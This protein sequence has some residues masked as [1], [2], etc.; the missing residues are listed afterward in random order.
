M[1][2][3]ISSIPYGKLYTKNNRPCILDPTRNKLLYLTPEEEVRQSVLNFIIETMKV[4][5]KMIETEVPMSYFIK[6][7][8]G[9]ADIIVYYEDEENILV[10]LLVIECK[11]KGV[12][13]IDKVFTQVYYYA[14]TIQAKYI[15][16]T[17]G[18]ELVIEKWKSENDS[19]EEVSNLPSYGELLSEENIKIQQPYIDVWKRTDFSKVNSKDTL[20]RYSS[21][22]GSDTP[23]EFNKLIINLQETL[24][25]IKEPFP[26]FERYGIKVIEDIGIR[27]TSFGNAA[28]FDWTGDY[29]SI[30][31]ESNKG[32]HSI[33]SFAIMYGYLLVAIDDDIRSHNSLQLKIKTHSIIDDNDTFRIQHN[34]KMAIGKSGGVKYSFVLNYVYKSEPDFV[35]PDMTKIYLGTLKNDKPFSWS[36]EAF[37]DFFMRLIRYGLLRDELRNQMKSN[38]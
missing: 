32:D 38:V 11:A 12:P 28:G 8:K 25:D 21:I 14:D 26:V 10:P 3:N 4:P 20:L 31:I 22:I 15:M 36:N 5:K 1:T 9:R 33:I 19:Y 6:G 23:K 27:Y 17:N 37:L 24:W 35:T 34:G 7:T 13:L 16:V 30:I 2:L 18:E 29:R